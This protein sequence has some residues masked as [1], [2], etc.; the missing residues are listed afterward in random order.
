LDVQQKYYN[1][2]PPGRFAVRSG[3][4]LAVPDNENPSKTTRPRTHAE[5]NEFRRKSLIEGAL[6]TLAEHGVAGTTVSRICTA[7]GS[8]RGLLNHYFDSKDDVMVAALQHMFGQISDSVQA[9]LDAKTPSP[10]D[11]LLTLPKAIFAKPAFSEVNRTAFLALW[12]ETR[13]NDKVRKANRLLYRDYI[14]RVDRLFSEAAAARGLSMDTRDAA[15][16]FIAMTDGMWLGLSIHDEV[17]TGQQAIKICQKYIAR[18][19]QLERID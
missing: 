4:E 14:D 16:G 5:I 6:R 19:L 2:C 13:F 18:E 3:Q 10:V 12:H 1:H 11:K 17:I 15:L 8:S 9:A 7:A